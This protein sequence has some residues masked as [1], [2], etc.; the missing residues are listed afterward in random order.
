MNSKPTSLCVNVITQA[1][2]FHSEPRHPVTA[3]SCSSWAVYLVNNVL[4][5]ATSSVS[6][7]Y[8]K[9]LLWKLNRSTQLSTFNR[10]AKNNKLT[11]K[12]HFR[13]TIPSSARQNLEDTRNTVEKPQIRFTASPGQAPG[14]KIISW[15]DVFIISPREVMQSRELESETLQNPAVLF[16]LQCN[17]IMVWTVILLDHVE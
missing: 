15:M 8:Y 14:Y 17:M 7:G 10:F 12:L 3:T 11:T 13:F 9:N 5:P 6:L 4:V 2:R 16:M 1:R